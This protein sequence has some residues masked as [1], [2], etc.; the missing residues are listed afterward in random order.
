MYP[1]C[2][3]SPPAALGQRVTL[4]VPDSFTQLHFIN[5]QKAGEETF[6]LNLYFC[7]LSDQLHLSEDYAT[8]QSTLG[9]RVGGGGGGGGENESC[10]TF[11]QS[12]LELWK[13][14]RVGQDWKTEAVKAYL[15]L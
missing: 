13:D 11:G 6:N 4:S 1:S 12:G 7:L 10:G 2:S 14:S 3:V 9:W 8:I 5:Q 15:K